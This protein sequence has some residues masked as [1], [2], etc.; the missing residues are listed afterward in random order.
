MLRR[1]LRT[2]NTPYEPEIKDITWVEQSCRS[3]TTSSLSYH[4]ITKATTPTYT[5]LR[6]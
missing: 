4:D 1:P 3:R 6:C 5:L 2:T